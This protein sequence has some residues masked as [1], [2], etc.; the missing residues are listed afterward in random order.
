MKTP[1]QNRLQQSAFE[2]A[3]ETVSSGVRAYVQDVKAGF[4][5]LHSIKQGPITFDRVHEGISAAAGT[6]VGLHLAGVV[7]GLGL[8]EGTI[9]SLGMLTGT[10]AWPV[11]LAAGLLTAVA[12]G[13]I[14]TAALG[15]SHRVIK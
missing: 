7:I 15:H 2:R 4:Q 8:K 11:A 3:G 10:V 1:E 9:I 14:P 13:T 12:V 6:G 5:F